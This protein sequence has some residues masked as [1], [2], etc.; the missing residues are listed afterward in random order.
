M[1]AETTL[2]NQTP[3]TKWSHR[4]LELGIFLKG[5]DAIFEILGGIF[6][7][8]MSNITLNQL[9]ISLT[10]HELIEDP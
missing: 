5:F 9:V 8:F 1:K 3:I 6:F 10:Q 4:A 2:K 7:W